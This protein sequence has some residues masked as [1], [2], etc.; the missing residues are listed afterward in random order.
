MSD[1]AVRRLAAAAGLAV[2]WEDIDGR[3]QTVEVGVLRDLLERLGLPCG[4]PA[5]CA[6]SLRLLETE[7]ADDFVTVIA[8]RAF[9]APGGEGDGDGLLLLESG[10]QR[11]ARPGASLRIDEIGYHRLQ[12]RDREI[13]IAACPPRARTAQERLGR[14]AWGLAVQLYA[15]CD[16]EPAGAGDF[17]ALA[18]FAHAVGQA[19]ADVLAISPA[20]ALFTAD[21]ARC[22]PY[23]PSSRDFLNPLLAPNRSGAGAVSE[24]I[25][26]PAFAEAKLQALRGDYAAMSADP[27][28]AAFV[29]DGGR[30]LA[31][32]A[33]FEAL[34]A[35]FAAEGLGVDWR[36]WPAPWQD[37][38]SPEVTRFVAEHRA[39][40]DFHLFLQWRADQ[41]LA[42]AQ[43]AALSAGMGLG[44]VS[45]LAVGL[46]PGGSH[47][48]SR[49]RELMAGLAI[50]A[51]PDAFQ[52]AGQNW[53]VTGF[54][55]RAL[56]RSGF[57]P[58][59]TTVRAAL[60]H[61][62]GVRIDHALGLKRLW[63]VPEGAPPSQGA[64]LSYPLQDLLRL[65]ALEAERAGA[66][67][68]GEDLGSVP[69]G[70]REILSDHGVMGMRVLPF[71]RDA[72]GAFTPV[73]GWDA[74]C[75]AMTSTHD[76]PPVAGWWRG[77][78]IAWRERLDAPGDR[79][80]ELA[81]RAGDRE[82]LWSRAL[83]DGVAQP[84]PPSPDAPDRAV[85]AAIDLAARSNC[86]LAVI[87]IEDLLG[88]DE[89]PNLPGVVDLH[90][91]WRRRLPAG[92]AQLFTRPEVAARLER[93]NRERPR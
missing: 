79:A 85:D 68:I 74:R 8:G 61:A 53:G 33:V 58:F 62:G 48:W 70:L 46:E 7:A 9:T 28:F 35:R 11:P 16:G 40:I 10:E 65:L 14:R 5:A 23:S 30:A 43:A 22:S 82:R 89:Q 38:S 2:V 75:V 52:A 25:D 36:G 54:D 41:G 51:P 60:R 93:L 39:E 24:L 31:S 29:A 45:D 91:N 6:D 37:P 76:L 88:L 71:E 72:G 18:Q 15:P 55:P 57:T 73:G 63:M 32:H 44:L 13:G 20:N 26:W 84:P 17:A 64:Y 66:V 80:A 69:P 21:P 86:E 87:P 50:G 34:S 77:R 83:A 1:E 78:D 27:T 12:L 47:A 59:L 92:A 3:S 49:R 81:A 56:R 4:A 19:G 90:P 42:Q 67:V